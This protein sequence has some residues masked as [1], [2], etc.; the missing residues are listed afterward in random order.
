[1]SALPLV[2]LHGWGTHAGV[3]ADV[4]ARLELGHQVIAPDFPG[5]DAPESAAAG[6]V[7][8][9]VDQL[10][11]IAPGRCVV[12]GWSLG[13]QIALAWARRYPQQVSRL[14]LIATTPRF[15]STADWP[16][17]MD[18]ATLAGFSTELS[19]DP[20]ATLRHF[21]LLQTQGDAQARGVARRLEAALAV[22][23]AADSKVLARTLGWL[24]DTDL[25][26]ALPDI[27]QP[28]LV[29]H[30]ERDR[31]TPF[32]AGE[33]L[34]RHLPRA[35]LEMFSGAAHAPFVSDPGAVCRL[36]TEF[37]HE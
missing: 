10:A 21:L 16:H 36:V 26:A 29:L 23:P 20:A 27:Q 37:C 24:R 19:A 1:M 12:A 13:G 7:D 15:L 9:V 32:A 6:T 30:G 4:I 25:R 28:A 17:G 8:E 2:L 18:A 22:R 14:V 33:Y 34:A 3:W 31:I 5:D 35:H 11:A